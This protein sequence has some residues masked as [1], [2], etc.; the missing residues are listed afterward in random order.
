MISRPTV[1]SLKPLHLLSRPEPCK[2][3]PV[4]VTG[5]SSLSAGRSVG[6]AVEIVI[7]STRRLVDNE[8]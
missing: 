4:H 3:K 7:V 6:A 2:L 5:S 1:Y 8:L